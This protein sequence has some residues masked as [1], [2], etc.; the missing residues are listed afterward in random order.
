MYKIHGVFGC[1]F[2]AEKIEKQNIYIYIYIYIYNIMFVCELAVEKR[3]KNNI[4]KLH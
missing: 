4:Y 3:E 1:D 2:V